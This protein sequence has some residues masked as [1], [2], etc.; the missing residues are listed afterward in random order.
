HNGRTTTLQGGSQIHG[1]T[2]IFDLVINTATSV[3]Q[4]ATTISIEG[5]FTNNGTFLPNSRTV[6]FTGNGN[7][8][9]ITGASF[10]T[11]KIDHSGAGNVT[12]ASPVTTTNLNA[13]QGTLDVATQTLTIDGAVSGTGTLTSAAT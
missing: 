11:L 2:T 8:Q 10:S 1:D 3:Q 9:T 6:A 13:T 12:L 4:F 5:S 7:T